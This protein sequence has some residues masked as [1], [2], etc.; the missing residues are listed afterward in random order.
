MNL[1][2]WQDLLKL[3][4]LAQEKN[5]TLPSVLFTPLHRHPDAYYRSCT[6]KIELNKPFRTTLEIAITCTKLGTVI[7]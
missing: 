3:A 7:V 4:S 1:H 5:L 6:T 2:S